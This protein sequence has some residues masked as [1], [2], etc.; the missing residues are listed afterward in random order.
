MDAKEA[1][2]KAELIARENDEK[3]YN[4]IK[5][6]IEECIEK[7]LFEYVRKDYISNKVKIKLEQEDY[8]VIVR[9]YQ[10]EI[11]TKISWY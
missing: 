5:V 8:K 3:Q 2:E 11:D 9:S 10:D 1:K 7:G 4:L 6:H